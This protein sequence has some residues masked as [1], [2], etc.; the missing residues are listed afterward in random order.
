V[1]RQ[2][3]RD[4]AQRA[5]VEQLV[6]PRARAHARAVDQERGPRAAALRQVGDATATSELDDSAW[7]F[8]S[9]LA[10]RPRDSQDGDSSFLG[11]SSEQ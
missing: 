7:N 6:H 11:E 5:R 9:V 2:V 10:G 3:D 1:S 4:H 8:V